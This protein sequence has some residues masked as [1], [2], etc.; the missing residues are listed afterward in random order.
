MWTNPDKYDYMDTK[1]LKTVC[2][3]NCALVREVIQMLLDKILIR[4]DV[5]GAITYVKSQI[6]ALLQYKMGISHLVIMKSLRSRNR[7]NS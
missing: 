6:S 4:Q 1:G 7:R 2:H 3:D 5:P